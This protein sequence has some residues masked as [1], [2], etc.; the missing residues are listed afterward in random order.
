M[1]RWYTAAA[2]IKSMMI[3]SLLLAVP[4]PS[5]NGKAPT[6]QEIIQLRTSVKNLEELAV[7]QQDRLQQH[8][9]E[10][11]SLKALVRTLELRI[12]NLENAVCPAN[13]PQ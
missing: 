11:E 4:A 9:A 13:T 1:T 5:D 10:S 3:L 8:K 2:M 6:K 7:E 12:A